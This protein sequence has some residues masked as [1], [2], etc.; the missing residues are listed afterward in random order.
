M[1]PMIIENKTVYGVGS[2]TGCVFWNI[3]SKGIECKR[4]QE[5]PDCVEEGYENIIYV[6]VEDSEN[7][8]KF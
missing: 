7:S 1:R 5:V 8:N 6:E 3:N 4:P 2:C